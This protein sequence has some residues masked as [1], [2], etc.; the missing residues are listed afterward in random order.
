MASVLAGQGKL[1][2]GQ[3]FGHPMV[4]VP[5]G[6]RFLR[7]RQVENIG[8]GGPVVECTFKLFFAVSWDV[9]EFTLMA[10]ALEHPFASNEGLE[11]EIYHNLFATLAEGAV[12]IGVKN[13]FLRHY[14]ELAMKPGNQEQS[15]H[16]ALSEQNENGL[17]TRRS[18]SSGNYC[19]TLKHYSAGCP[20][21]GQLDC[22][23][24]FH[25][26]AAETGQSACSVKGGAS[27]NF[28]LG[29]EKCQGKVENIF[30]RRRDGRRELC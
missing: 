22:R 30:W 1:E 6:S 26:R 5:S 29:Q 12:F 3:N 8:S 14:V 16:E 18:R 13:A 19:W 4:R 27:N 20:V 9:A 15:V 28:Q 7:H 10:L 24:E 21:V 25:T 17:S 2:H 11:V 23:P